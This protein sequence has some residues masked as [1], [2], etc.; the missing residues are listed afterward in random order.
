LTALRRKSLSLLPFITG[1]VTTLSTYL[2]Q[3]GIPEG[4]YMTLSVRL[5]NELRKEIFAYAKKHGLAHSEAVRVLLEKALRV[6][7]P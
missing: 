7:C 1:T 6:D 4:A 5:A 2:F 3:I